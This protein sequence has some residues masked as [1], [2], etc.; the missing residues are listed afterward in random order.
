MK[1]HRCKIIRLHESGSPFAVSLFS[2]QE[3]CQLLNFDM[4]LSLEHPILSPL[5]SEN[6]I[7]PVMKA[8]PAKVYQSTS[9]VTPLEVM[10]LTWHR[11][12]VVPAG[13]GDADGSPVIF[14]SS[15]RETDSRSRLESRADG[16]VDD[17]HLGF[18]RSFS[19][20]ER[21]MK[22]VIFH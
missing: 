17:S 14:T 19:R 20:N 4:V 16:R 21:E 8:N 1:N 22:S 13:C 6:T 7:Q 18:A 12:I 10:L 15:S 2:K 5:I 11:W 9:F 3:I